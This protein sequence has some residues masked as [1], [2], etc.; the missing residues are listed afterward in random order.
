[1]ALV[2]VFHLVPGKSIGMA[3]VQYLHHV[4]NAIEINFRPSYSERPGKAYN[5]SMYAVYKDI[6]RPGGHI[7][8]KN[9]L[10]PEPII[11]RRWL[12]ASLKFPF[13]N[14]RANLGRRALRA[15][16]LSPKI[17]SQPPNEHKTRF[18]TPRHLQIGLDQRRKP[19]PRTRLN[20]LCF[21]GRLVTTA[22]YAV[23]ASNTETINRKIPKDE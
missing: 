14:N 15:A 4:S 21:D 18:A 20:L 23:H 8:I 22:A 16:Q 11:V 9:L 1:M 12:Y 6:E 3:G 5:R 19:L 7:A 13:G 2:G 10:T 17:H